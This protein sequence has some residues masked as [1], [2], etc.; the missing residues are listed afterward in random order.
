LREEAKGHNKAAKATAFVT[1]KTIMTMGIDEKK[2]KYNSGSSYMLTSATDGGYSDPK[3]KM[4]RR[5]DFKM[6]GNTSDYIFSVTWQAC[7]AELVFRPMI[8]T[9]D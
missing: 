1:E 2:V 4:Q 6:E 3:R 9:L 7:H 8:D 5:P